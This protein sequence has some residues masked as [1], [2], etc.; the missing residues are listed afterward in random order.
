MEI[1]FYNR[2]GRPVAYTTDWVAIYLY[3]GEPVAYLSHDA[4]YTF[5]GTH[6]GWFVDGR[7][8][9]H[10]GRDV[11][12]TGL[13]M[14]QPAIPVGLTPVRKDIRRAMPGRQT[15]EAKPALPERVYAWAARSSENYFFP[16]AV[17][18]AYRTPC[19]PPVPFR[20]LGAHN[21]SIRETG[22]LAA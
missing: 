14:G 20:V 3:T 10:A 15:R 13:A 5:A 8:V 9:D 1:V 6:L 12:F 19:A 7:I 16:I 11:F 21:T 18:A 4:V 2:N 22:A 17:P